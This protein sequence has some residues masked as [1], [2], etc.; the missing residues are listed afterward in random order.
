M[1]KKDL[2][3]LRSKDKEVLIKEIDLKRLDLLKTV[4]EKS[5]SSQK[6]LKKAKNLRRDLSQLLTILKEKDI[7]QVKYRK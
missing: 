1:K 4:V 6:N 3:T 5:S 7:F 2:E